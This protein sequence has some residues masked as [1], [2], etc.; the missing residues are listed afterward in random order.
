MERVC[1]RPFAAIMC[2]VSPVSCPP[3]RKSKAQS[4]SQDR[5]IKEVGVLV[6]REERLNI[7]TSTSNPLRP[8]SPGPPLS[9]LSNP[10]SVVFFGPHCLSLLI[11]LPLIQHSRSFSRRSFQ[12]KPRAVSRRSPRTSRSEVWAVTQG[13]SFRKTVAELEVLSIIPAAKSRKEPR[14]GGAGAHRGCCRTPRDA[15]ARPAAEG[16]GWENEWLQLCPIL[17]HR[18]AGKP[19]YFKSQ[20]GMTTSKCKGSGCVCVCVCVSCSVMSVSLQLQGL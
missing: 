15:W 2:A 5:G 18:M 17:S 13:K 16:P 1:G 7:K 9:P 14:P 6:L 3:T 10:F 20:H 4:G 12:M 19:R 8:L 11:P